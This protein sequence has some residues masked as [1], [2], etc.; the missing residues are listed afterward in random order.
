MTT[1]LVATFEDSLRGLEVT[2][3]RTTSE[4]F[5]AT[6]MDV[7]EEPAVGAPLPFEELSLADTP[8]TLDPTPTELTGATTGVT[9]AGA[10]IAE[11]GTLMIQSRPGGDEPV[12]LY[13]ERHVAVLR[14]SDLVAGVPEAISWL[15]EEFDAGNK[16]AIFA[17]GASA[18]ADMGALVEGVHG[19]RDVHVIIVTDL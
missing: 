1:D 17:S 6:V 12:S 16:S 13:A 5:E 9:A 7:I 19:P 18:T 2:W 14:Q 10:G 3:D 4:E 11:Y 15:G 8:V